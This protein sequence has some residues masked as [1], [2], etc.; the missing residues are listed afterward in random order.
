MIELRRKDLTVNL[1]VNPA[2]EK[3]VP[4]LKTAWLMLGLEC[5][6]TS[7]KD[8][9]HSAKSSHYSGNGLD[10]RI[11]DISKHMAPIAFGYNLANALLSVCGPGY[12]VVLEGDHI[13]L[14][15]SADVPN[16]KGWKKGKYFY[17][18]T[19]K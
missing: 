11:W 18:G 15:Y 12:Y 6:V 19:G 4:V 1:E 10:L 14:E 3:A 7:G 13:H 16:I 2:F 5:V 17:D 9:V 8:G